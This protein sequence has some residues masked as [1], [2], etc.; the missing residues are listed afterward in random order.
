[1]LRILVLLLVAA[2]LGY[3]AWTRG[4]L[5]AFGWMPERFSQSE[6]QRLA[7][8]IH[9]EWLQIG[10]TSASA[11]AGAPSP[12]PPPPPSPSP[13]VPADEGEGERH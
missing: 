12:S 3:L 11:A 1:M 6:P 7:Q 10:P 2:N 9:P 5:A 13:A 8:Q 4:A